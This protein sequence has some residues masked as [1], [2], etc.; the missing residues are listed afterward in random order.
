MLWLGTIY[1]GLDPLH[2]RIFSIVQF[3]KK[4]GNSITEC[5]R[6]SVQWVD[7]SRYPPPWILRT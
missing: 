4:S 2:F 1:N 6:N 3:S 5:K 7:L